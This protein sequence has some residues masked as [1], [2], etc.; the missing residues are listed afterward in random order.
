MLPG[1]NLTYLD[2]N[3]IAQ[4]LVVTFI[5]PV[6]NE[7]DKM[8]KFIPVPLTPKQERLLS[9]LRSSPLGIQEIQGALKVTKP[10][11]HFILKPLLGAGLVKRGG[12]HKTGKYSLA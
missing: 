9:L 2:W 3:I 6:T 5:S 11:A 4:A 10:G 8:P 12:G 7:N 1:Y